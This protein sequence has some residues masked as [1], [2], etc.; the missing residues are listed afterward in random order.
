MSR[1]SV[2]EMSGGKGPRQMLWERMRRMSVRGKEFSLAEIVIGD[3]SLKT[4]QDYAASL[5]KGGWLEVT[6]ARGRVASGSQ[7]TPARFRLARDNGVEAPRVRRDG[8][9][10]IQGLAQEQMWRTLRMLKCDCS[11]RELAAQASTEAVRVSPVAARD[12]LMNLRR[13][14]YVVCTQEGHGTGRGGIPARYRLVSNTGPHAPQVCRVDA[15]FDP[16]LG[17]EI[18]RRPADFADWEGVTHGH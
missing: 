2:T 12:Y 15:M 4:A 1:K 11:A 6:Q 10:V 8:T 14:S 9:L 16:N 13:A 18:W 3:E 5:V 7:L 17:K